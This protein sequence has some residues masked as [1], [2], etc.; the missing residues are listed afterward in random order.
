MDPI[1]LLIGIGLVATSLGILLIGALVREKKRRKERIAELV[2]EAEREQVRKIIEESHLPDGAMPV[3]S[4][5]ASFSKALQLPGSLMA[6]GIGTPGMN[7]LLRFLIELYETGLADA[8][9]SL[10]VVN[11]DRLELEKFKASL[12]S[13][14]HDRVVY[15]A[16]DEFGSGMGN[17]PYEEVKQS[18]GYYGVTLQDKTRE[19]VSLHQRRIAGRRPGEIML[20]GTSGGHLYIGVVVARALHT[21]IPNIDIIAAIDLPDDEPLRDDFLHAKPEYEANGVWGWIVS[22][23]LE[24]YSITADTALANLL[25]GIYA[26]SLQDDKTPRLNNIL[27]RVLPMERGGMVVY[28]FLYSQVTAYRFQPHESVPATYYASRDQVVT[29]LKTLMG[30]MEA[31]KGIASVRAPLGEPH[32][33]TYD[34]VLASIYPNFML[35]VA[36]GLKEARRLEATVLPGDPHHALFQQ[37]NYHTLHASYPARMNPNEPC[38]ELG[39]IRLRALHEWRHSLPE[40]VKAPGARQ[41]REVQLPA[42]GAT[43]HNGKN[44]IP[45]PKRGG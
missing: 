35:E 39:V 37:P 27:R 21:L 33:A 11:F 30:Y 17:R 24:F 45:T 22:D 42:E 9:G 2:Q 34:L 14:Y 7:R 12:P 15:A 3:C 20:F 38:C 23:A 19:A 29:E 36:D 40:I 32:R 26:A 41:F 31:G 5:R 1:T 6:I 16:A 18:I 4:N 8:I 10:L 44:S 13:Y 43:S 25:T 28:Q